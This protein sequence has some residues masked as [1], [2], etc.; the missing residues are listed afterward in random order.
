MKLAELCSIYH[1]LD[2]F[3]WLQNKLPSNA[4]EAARA[5]AMKEETIE[6]INLGLA[7]ADK[8]RLDRYDYVS[9]DKNLRSI[10]TRNMRESKDGQF[11]SN[12]ILN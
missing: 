10:W 8:L 2:L 9:K 12:A 6:K 1:E 5:N 11:N 3:I 7:H 4:V